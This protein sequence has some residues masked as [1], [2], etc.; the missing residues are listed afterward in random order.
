M[1]SERFSCRVLLFSFLHQKLQQHRGTAGRATCWQAVGKQADKFTNRHAGTMRPWC[2]VSPYADGSVSIIVGVQTQA[3]T[4]VAEEIL[5]YTD[6]MMK[7]KSKGGKQVQICCS[8]KTVHQ[9]KCRSPIFCT[10]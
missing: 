6:E 2:P 3:S 9:G 7:T 10:G 8:L 4:K 5:F 1:R